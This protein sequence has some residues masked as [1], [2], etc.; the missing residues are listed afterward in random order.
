MIRL[1][2]LRLENFLSHKE[3]EINF[4]DETYVIL[5]ENASGKTSILRGIFFSIF[6]KD[7]VVDKQ[8]KLVN[9]S[10]ARFSTDVR[11][12]YRGREIEVRRGF[13]LYTKRSSAE[14]FVDGRLAASGVREVKK[15][16]EEVLNLDPHIFRNTV[17][18]PQGEILSL[19]DLQKKEKRQILNRLLGL[20]EIGETFERVK[21]FFRVLESFRNVLLQEEENFQLLKK[22]LDE[23]KLKIKEKERKLTEILGILKEEKALLE[24]QEEILQ[25]LEEKRRAAAV[26]DSEIKSCSERIGEV[27]KELRGIRRKIEEIE[28]LKR[29]LPFLAEKLE[30]LAPLQQI[31]EVLT[32]VAERKKDLVEKKKTLERLKELG[33]ELEG[34]E[35]SIPQLDKQLKD[36]SSRLQKLMA[37]LPTLQKKLKG[38]EEK[39]REKLKLETQLFSVEKELKAAEEKLNFLQSKPKVSESEVVKLKDELRL[40]EKEESYKEAKFREFQK[41]LEELKNL[42][43]NVCPVCLSSLSEE[44]REELIRI[45]LEEA[46]QLKSELEELKEKRKR[47]ESKLKELEDVLLKQKQEEALKR[48]IALNVEKLRLKEKQIREDLKSYSVEEKEIEDLRE[49]VEGVQEEVASLR[50]KKKF[51]ESQLEEK[52]RKRLEIKKLVEQQDIEVLEKEVKTLE[53][54]IQQALNRAKDIK[55]SWNLDVS[56][57]QDVNAKIEE[58]L[59]LKEK[60]NRME[61]EI[62]S[63]PDFERALKEKE[64]NL[65]ALKSRLSKLKKQLEELGFNVKEYETMKETVKREREK[66]KS[67][68]REVS[69]LS[70]E[71]S[72]Y[73]KVIAGK[74]EKLKGEKKLTFELAR[75][76]DTLRIL[77]S[78]LEGLHPE[79]GFLTKV[80]KELLPEVSHYCT[81]FFEEFDF[82]FGDVTIS[83]DLGVTARGLGGQLTL[84]EFSG[85]QQI[86]FALSLRFALAKYFSQRFDLLILDEPTIHL[87]QQRRQALTDLLQKLKMKIPQMIIVTHDPELEVVGDVVVKVEKVGGFSEVKVEA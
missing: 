26:L 2:G 32:G 45:S 75:T 10:A 8:E 48:E 18:V 54:F 71:I 60:K 15:F 73:G 11:F 21:K 5:G 13:S 57:L 30:V 83:E 44:R 78:V 47:L 19:F 17:Y 7:F 61:G 41:R 84:N 43:S 82:E 80:R 31:R 34:L 33:V 52:K 76:E 53:E 39:R 55:R 50:E 67:L 37:V 56:S 68:E 29:E 65:L 87:D 81:E 4:S 58:L 70:G 85:G 42:E 14:L 1:R 38:L 6:G 40:L 74:E 79:R 24:K 23:T 27:E 64:K 51:L 25:G 66:V 77:G 46:E 9:K 35:T 16:I 36:V 49:R 63:L 69:R 3:T 28:R 62:R 72:T 86:A 22:E 12:V 20:D 59:K